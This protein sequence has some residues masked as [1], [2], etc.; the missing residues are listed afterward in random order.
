M[1]ALSSHVKACYISDLSSV[2][3][4]VLSWPVR[5]LDLVL[6]IDMQIPYQGH[7]M[8]AGMSSL[9]IVSLACPA[10]C[11]CHSNC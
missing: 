2:F 5:T 11:V 8:T 10:D 3:V 9:L 4:S 6:L 7:S 1:S